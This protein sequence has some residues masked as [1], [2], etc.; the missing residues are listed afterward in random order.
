MRCMFTALM[1][2]LA[3]LPAGSRAIEPIQ[4]AGRAS[5]AGRYVQESEAAGE[6]QLLL[7]QDGRYEL[8]VDVGLNREKIRTIHGRWTVSD[9]DVLLTQQARDRG[10]PVFVLTQVMPWLPGAQ[11]ALKASER[12]H[13]TALIRSACPFVETYE[14]GISDA[15]L[16]N[17]GAPALVEADNQPE[18]KP[19]A[20]A[21]LPAALAAT[22]Q[23][24]AEVESAIAAAMKSQA[25]HAQ[26]P[27]DAARAASATIDAQTAERQVLA[28]LQRLRETGYL[29]AVAGRP[30]P[31]VREPVFDR[32]HC[33]SEPPTSADRPGY[34]VV[35]E[36]SDD[37]YRLQGLLIDFVYSDGRIERREADTRGSA[38]APDRPGARLKQLVFNIDLI[39]AQMR[40]ENPLAVEVRA[41]TLAV[42]ASQ[43]RTFF[44]QA[45]SF[46]VLPDPFAEIPLI[47]EDGALVSARSDVRYVRH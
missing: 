3:L 35:V 44:V 13:R 31:D 41:E 33:L 12:E 26:A 39:A 37:Y 22:E 28:Y 30:M 7:R 2:A 9:Q 17:L 15:H 21:A 38:M 43:G 27:D 47:L 29:H 45:D 4:D 18:R 20:V 14:R 10:K 32:E 5:L 19:A 6:S 36:Y 24:R 8:S 11:D 42:D 46:A 25:A 16:A 40:G 34:A 23:S 1:V